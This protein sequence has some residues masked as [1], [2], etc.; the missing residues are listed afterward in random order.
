MSR[1]SLEKPC[2]PQKSFGLFVF[3]KLPTHGGTVFR[4]KPFSANASSLARA[5]YIDVL[6]RLIM[7]LDAAETKFARLSCR[8]KRA[9]GGP[10]DASHRR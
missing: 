3:V 6:V 4:C 7:P 5:N 2:A 8:E 10:N 9:A 1:K